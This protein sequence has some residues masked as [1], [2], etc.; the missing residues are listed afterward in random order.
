MDG[1]YWVNKRLDTW[2]AWA[3]KCD[4]AGLGYPKQSIEGRLMQY[5]HYWPSSGHCSEVPVDPIAEEVDLYIRELARFEQKLA[6]ALR[7]FYL[8]SGTNVEKSALLCCSYTQFKV[9]V[10]HARYWL[11]GRM[12]IK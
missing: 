5:G 8:G 9:H 12:I 7:L 10:D 4:L 1:I 11:A 6:A 3:L 2:A